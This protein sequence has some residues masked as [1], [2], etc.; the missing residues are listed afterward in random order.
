MVD[1]GHAY[2]GGVGGVVAGVWSNQSDAYRALI[3]SPLSVMTL[4]AM[5]SSDGRLLV[6]LG[7]MVF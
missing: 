6:D 2:G 1:G 7:S 4:W 5:V 3:P